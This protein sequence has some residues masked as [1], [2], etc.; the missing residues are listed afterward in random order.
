MSNPPMTYAQANME[1]ALLSAEAQATSS[2]NVYAWLRQSGLPSEA[3]LRLEGLVD[4]TKDLGGHLVSRGKIIAV[5]VIAFA[6][7]HPNLAAGVAIGAAI[8]V[9]AG[10]IPVLG[11]YLWPIATLAGVSI[12][13]IAGHR[14][15]KQADGKTSKEETNLIAIAQDVIEIAREFFQLIIEIFTT[16]LNQKSPKEI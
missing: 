5:K 6:K 4:F 12:G 8:G 15:D 16:V 2:S 7:A 14:I 13:A 1:L 10:T 9:L 3:A 11:P